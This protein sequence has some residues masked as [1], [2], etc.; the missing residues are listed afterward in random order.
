M[1]VTIR[2]NR[3]SG[4]YRE[5]KYNDHRPEP[6][7]IGTHKTVVFTEPNHRGED[8]TKVV[9]HQTAVV[10]FNEDTIL[11]NTGGYETRTTMLRMN[12]TSKVYNL[13]FEVFQKDFTW[14]VKF[15]EVTKEFEGNTM[16]I[17]RNGWNWEK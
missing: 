9:Y 12:Q 4:K 10:S 1:L 14:Y 16:V 2:K 5:F 11:L 17:D 7:K 6:V 8:T 3:G 13:G 15:N